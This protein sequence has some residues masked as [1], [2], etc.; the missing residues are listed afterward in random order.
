M[1]DAANLMTLAIYA[2]PEVEQAWRRGYTKASVYRLLK[3]YGRLAQGA[4]L[5]PAED[6]IGSQRTRPNDAP[7]TATAVMKA[8]LESALKALSFERMMVLFEVIAVGRA[9]WRVAEFWGLTPAALS[10]MVE[11]TL[12][13]LVDRLNGDDLPPAMH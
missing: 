5:T 13:A 6:R 4:R 9:R 11:D 8:D 12:C 10:G 1:P 3:D 7:W 2:P